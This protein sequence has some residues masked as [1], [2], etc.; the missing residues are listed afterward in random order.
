MPHAQRLH[1][2]Y[3]SQMMMCP[4][5]LSGQKFIRAF[6]K[7]IYIYIRLHLHKLSLPVVT[8]SMVGTLASRPIDQFA[9]KPV[10]DTSCT[11]HLE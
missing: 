1:G 7:F 9:H 4:A 3:T 2:C 8:R 6:R 5:G 10:A 11:L